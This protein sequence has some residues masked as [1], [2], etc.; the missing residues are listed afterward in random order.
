MLPTGGIGGAGAVPSAWKTVGCEV[1]IL[2]PAAGN[3]NTAR[4]S[5]VVQTIFLNSM[6]PPLRCENWVPGGAYGRRAGHQSRKQGCAVCRASS[7]GTGQDG[8]KQMLGLWQGATG[9]PAAVKALLEDPVKRGL[10]PARR[11]LLALEGSKPRERESNMRPCWLPPRGTPLPGSGS[12]RYVSMFAPAIAWPGT[13]V[14]GS[15]LEGIVPM[16]LAVVFAPPR[17]ASFSDRPGRR[18]QRMR[19][20]GSRKHLA[21]WMG[22]AHTA[23]VRDASPGWAA[24]LLPA[25]GNGNSEDLSLTADTMRLQ[26]EAQAVVASRACGPLLKR[27]PWVVT[28]P[29]TSLP[30]CSVYAATMGVG[31]IQGRGSGSGGGA[32]PSATR[33]VLSQVESSCPPSGTANATNSSRVVQTAFRKSMVSSSCGNWVFRPKLTKESRSTPSYFPSQKMMAERV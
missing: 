29:R 5:R 9:N 2:S 17:S 11:Y 21:I 1:K 16:P 12:V 7:T 27:R 15:H 23:L 31:A 30:A 3:T 22:L 13:R 28:F 8:A 19:T 32:G 18:R 26:L 4:A 6:V 10:D 20:A 33:T 24:L 25:E 14:P